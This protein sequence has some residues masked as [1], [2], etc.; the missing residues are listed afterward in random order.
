MY[1]M[2]PGYK[3]EYEVKIK[4]NFIIKPRSKTFKTGLYI[5]LVYKKELI[6]N[7]VKKKKRHVPV[8][9]L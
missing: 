6:K 3:I 1:S 4:V 2:G 5:K 9:R 8:Y 7:T